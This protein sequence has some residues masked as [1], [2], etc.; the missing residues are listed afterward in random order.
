MDNATVMPGLVRPQVVLL[1]QDDK[2]QRLTSFEQSQSRGAAQDAASHN[3]DIVGQSLQVGSL[4]GV[5]CAG[6]GISTIRLPSSSAATL[7]I[8]EFAL[9]KRALGMFDDS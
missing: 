3:S 4:P 8:A 5:A 9:G 6:T 7:Q 2:T 1:L